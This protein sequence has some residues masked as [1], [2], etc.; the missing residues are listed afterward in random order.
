M[1]LKAWTCGVAMGM[2]LAGGPGY[3]QDGTGFFAL[4]LEGFASPVKAERCNLL[5]ELYEFPRQC[6]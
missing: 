1:N 5:L 6:R 2:V 4:N 3:A